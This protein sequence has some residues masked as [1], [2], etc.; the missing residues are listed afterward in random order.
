MN[1]S[2]APSQPSARLAL[3]LDLFER[4]VVAALLGHFAWRIL[5]NWIE[6]GD[7]VGLILLSSEGA[8]VV[9][10]LIRRLSTE[11]SMRPA[12]WAL[13]TLG[14]AMPLLVVPVHG[15]ALASAAV[16]VPLMLA[17]SFLQIAAKFTLR[18]SFGL[19]AANRG[20][21]VG[22]PYRL[23][24]HPMYAGYLMIHIGFLIA[25]PS[26]W[27]LAIYSAG[28]AFQIGRILAEEKILSRDA[29]YREFARAVPYWFIPR[30]I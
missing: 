23:I 12:D 24:R 15:E 17:G 26:I 25:N 27:N 18:R 20:V 30:V 10:C 3:A 21:K 14:T 5:E 22:G 13:A 11:M 16:F 9:L 2:P 8:I 29:A 4:V 28:L 6:T 7:F 1:Q 19:V